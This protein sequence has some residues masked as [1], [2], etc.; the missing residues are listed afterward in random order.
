MILRDLN[1][2]SQIEDEET[3]LIRQEILQASSAENA[4]IRCVLLDNSVYSAAGISHELFQSPALRKM[5]SAIGDMIGNRQPADAVTVSEYLADRD[6]HID[7]LDVA[8]NTIRNSFGEP[9][10]LD[11][12]VKIL[13]ELHAKRKV[14]EIA[15][16]LLQG[17]TKDIGSV[18]IAIKQLMELGQVERRYEHDA[19]QVLKAAVESTETSF[20]KYQSGET[21]GIPTGLSEV[22]DKTGGFH[23]TDLVV[24][25]ARPAMSKTSLSLN[26]AINCN[27]RFGFISCEQSHD[28]MGMRLISIQGQVSGNRMRKGTLQEEDWGRL[29]AGVGLL[30]DRQ[31]WVNDDPTI[32]IDQIISQARKWKYSYD[33][34]ILFID[35]IQR[36]YATDRRMSSIQKVEATTLGLK[37]LAKELSIPVVALGQVNRECEK[38][39]DKRPMVSDAAD[40]SIIEKE[41]DSIWTLY[42]DEVYNP[43]TEHKGI[44][45]IGI[46]KNRHGPTGVIRTSWRGEYFK[47]SDLAP[48]YYKDRFG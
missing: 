12:Y 5:Y 43:D 39:P 27:K 3:Y 20:Q 8:V 45:E 15:D 29:T 6:P 10:R 11:S 25:I 23:D 41:A 46:C 14:R 1:E 24:I 26:L 22:D 21:V 4:L 7:W 2:V 47:F 44:A 42:R 19:A 34:K 48:E 9:E 40:A 35:Y 36:V 37:S 31:F 30:K 33:I 17:I 16:S 28:Q 38:R 32:N 18:D 13:N